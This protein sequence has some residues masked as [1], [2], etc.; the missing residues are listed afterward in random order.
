MP[1]SRPQAVEYG[2]ALGV[3]VEIVTKTRRSKS[4]V[5]SSADR[6]SNAPPGWLMQHRRL[7]RDYEARPGTSEA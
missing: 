1:D 2:A 3:D 4:S 7:V 5:W 6:S